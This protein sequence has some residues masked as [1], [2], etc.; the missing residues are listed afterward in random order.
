MKIITFNL[1]YFLTSIILLL[2]LIAIAAFVNDRFIR[3]FIGDALVVVWMYV[4]LKAFVEM[5]YFKLANCVLFFSYTIEI[6]QF[7]KLVQILGLEDIA[8]ARIII[9]STFDWLDF[10]A[11]TIGWIVVLLIEKYRLSKSM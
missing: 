11:Y 1:K 4:F 3:P 5:H 8:I 6:A 7:F 10:V 2:I 9:G